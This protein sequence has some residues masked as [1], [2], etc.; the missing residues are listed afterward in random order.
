VETNSNPA[1]TKAERRRFRI[2]FLVLG[3]IFVGLGAVGVVL[4][5]I[6]TTPFLLVAAACFARSSPRFHSWLLNSRLFGP[7]I[8][9]RQE[10]HTI[11]RG[12]KATAISMVVVVAG[13]S[14]FFFI[15]NLWTRIIILAVVV[16]VGFWILSIPSAKGPEIRMEK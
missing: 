7:T 12:V 8:R 5:V 3:W 6:P 11:S 14:A 16:A 9:R 2:L 4:P 1:V 15:G 13:S 10:T